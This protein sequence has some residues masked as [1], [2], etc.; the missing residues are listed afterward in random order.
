M[1]GETMFLYV[2]D[3]P[4]EPLN[5]R[6]MH[7]TSKPNQDSGEMGHASFADIAGLCD[8]KHH[9]LELD[10]EGYVIHPCCSLGFVAAGSWHAW[11]V[12]GL[13]ALE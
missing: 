12:G 2:R 5:V 7:C 1:Y 10:V 6:L 9:E 11:R 4:E 13:V 8:G 3:P